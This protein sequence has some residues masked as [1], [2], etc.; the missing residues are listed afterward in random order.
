MKRVLAWVPTISGSSSHA[1]DTWLLG[2]G[3]TIDTPW[4]SRRLSTDGCI[5]LTNGRAVPGR[6]QH[7]VRNAAWCLLQHVAMNR[8]DAECLDC[9]VSGHL[10][11]GYFR[12]MD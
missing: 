7:A 6:L 10:R 4:V 8:H 5:D 12:R 9:C 2:T 1:F 11:I 3:W